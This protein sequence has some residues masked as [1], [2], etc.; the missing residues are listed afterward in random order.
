M[1]VSRKILCIHSFSS[2]LLFLNSDMDIIWFLLI[3][4][5]F[6]PYTDKFSGNFISSMSH[7]PIYIFWF[8]IR[9]FFSLSFKNYPLI[10]YSTHLSFQ[11]MATS[12]FPLKSS[13][14]EEKKNHHLWQQETS[15]SSHKPNINLVLCRGCVL[16]FSWKAPWHIRKRACSHVSQIY[17]LPLQLLNSLI[18]AKFLIL[19]SFCLSISTLK[20]APD[21]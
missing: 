9:T 21:K 4:S 20:S 18:L 11:S 3:S 13:V 12:C 10:V 2:P 14:E 7:I 16:M 15:F 8:G 17:D 19:T 6:L 1:D 5:S